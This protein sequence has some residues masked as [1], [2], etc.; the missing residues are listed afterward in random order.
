METSRLALAMVACCVLSTT[1]CGSF[2]L[3]SPSSKEKLKMISAG[4]TGCMPADNE[5]TNVNQINFTGDSTWN[6]TC[7]SRTY[8][9]TSTGTVHGETFSCAPMAQ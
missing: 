6:A 9:C 5:I 3:D 1:G 4:H 2:S 8:L 7:K